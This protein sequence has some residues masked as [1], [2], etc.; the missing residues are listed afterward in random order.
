VITSFLLYARRFFRPI[1]DL[2]EKYN[3]LQS[4]IASSE[5]VFDLIDRDEEVADPELPGLACAP[6]GA[7]ARYCPADRAR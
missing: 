5:R 3:L 7:R 1:Q 2:S 6:G 4:A